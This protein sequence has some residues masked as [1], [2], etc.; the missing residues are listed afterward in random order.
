MNF[1]N[2]LYF[3]LLFPYKVNKNGSSLCRAI[4]PGVIVNKNPMNR[5]AMSE[6]TSLDISSNKL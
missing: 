1:V 6:A 3:M 5:I 4:Y 2:H